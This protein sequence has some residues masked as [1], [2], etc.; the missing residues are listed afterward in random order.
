MSVAQEEDNEIV[1]QG[2]ES[3]FSGFAQSDIVGVGVAYLLENGARS[4]ITVGCMVLFIEFSDG[5]D[6]SGLTLH[7]LGETDVLLLQRCMVERVEGGGGDR[8]CD[9]YD[10]AG[11]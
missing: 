10:H 4:V 1:V 6:E 2:G 3:E 8:K 7:G 11:E 9:R 5:L